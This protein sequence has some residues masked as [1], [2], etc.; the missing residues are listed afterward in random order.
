MGPYSELLLFLCPFALRLLR[1]PFALLW[2]QPLFCKK[3]IVLAS[4]IKVEWKQ[5]CVAV[6]TF[7]KKIS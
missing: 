4:S 2:P 5:Y 7:G 1:H 3:A 6:L